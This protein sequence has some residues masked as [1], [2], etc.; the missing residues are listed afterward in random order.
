M[1][2]RLFTAG[3]HLYPL[4]FIG[5]WTLRNKRQRKYN[6]NDKNV[7]ENTIHANSFNALHVTSAPKHKNKQV[8][9]MD[10]CFTNFTCVKTAPNKTFVVL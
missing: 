3:P 8:T 10:N 7:F 6:R 9:L 4:W 1:A 2:C 5:N